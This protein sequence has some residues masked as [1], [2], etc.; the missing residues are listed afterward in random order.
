MK[1]GG[2]EDRV[3]SSE[4]DEP[5]VNK[6]KSNFPDFTYIKGGFRDGPLPRGEEGFP[7]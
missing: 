7:P 3:D 5:K 2:G 6:Q 1:E 4:S